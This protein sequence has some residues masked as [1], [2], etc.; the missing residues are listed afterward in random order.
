MQSCRHN[1][2][3]KYYCFFS[4]YGFCFMCCITIYQYCLYKVSVSKLFL[5]DLDYLYTNAYAEGTK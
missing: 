2:I 3:S 4:A 5:E 1:V